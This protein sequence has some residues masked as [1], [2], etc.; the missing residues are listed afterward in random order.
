M[1]LSAPKNVTWWISLILAV[2]AVL[3]KFVVIPF[4]TA[5]GFWLLAVAF[6]LLWLGTLLK[7]L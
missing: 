7:G 6:L 5:N 4:C 2:L 3:G 1:K